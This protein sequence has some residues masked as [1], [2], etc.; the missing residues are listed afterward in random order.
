M[1][2]IGHLTLQVGATKMRRNVGRR[3]HSDATH[4]LR[5]KGISRIFSFHCLLG[6]FYSK[7]CK[8]IILWCHRSLVFTNFCHLVQYVKSLLPIYF[9]FPDFFDV[10]TIPIR[11]FMKIRQTVD[12]LIEGHKRTEVVGISTRRS[13]FTSST[14]PNRPFPMTASVRRRSAAARLL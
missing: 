11:N 2:F 9:N 14:T 5:R 1:I 12:S 10:R 7:S 6:H 3:T 8:L 4:H 13:F